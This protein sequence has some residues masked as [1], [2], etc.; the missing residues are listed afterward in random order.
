MPRCGL[1]YE[2]VC[3][4]FFGKNVIDDVIIINESLIM[5]CLLE[6]HI[7]I[8]TLFGSKY[9]FVVVRM[10]FSVVDAS[11]CLSRAATK[12]MFDEF[13]KCENY[14]NAH[15]F[16]NPNFSWNDVGNKPRF[17]LPSFALLVVFYF[18]YMSIRL[19]TFI[20]D[21]FLRKNLFCIVFG[22]LCTVHAYL[23]NTH[24]KNVE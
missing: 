10:I 5:I 23:Q 19:R 18:K 17:I 12:I 21:E 8:Y 24:E 9:I 22:A 20:A 15:F 16:E 7:R 2:Y 13:E 1:Q 4:L 3:L 14:S 11:D 6:N